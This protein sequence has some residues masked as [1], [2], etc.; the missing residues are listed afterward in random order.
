MS[1]TPTLLSKDA[2][3]GLLGVSDRTLEKLVRQGQFPPPLR[4]GKTVRW[5]EPVVHRWMTMQLEAQLS[6]EPLRPRMRNA[7]AR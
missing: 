7:K 2:V 4:L 6:W 3:L 5:A 1:I